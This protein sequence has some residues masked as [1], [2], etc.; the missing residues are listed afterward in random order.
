LHIQAIFY[1][2]INLFFP[3]LE[4]SLCWAYIGRE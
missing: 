3:L 2:N 4:G 1:F